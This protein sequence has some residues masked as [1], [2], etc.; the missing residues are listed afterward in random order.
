MKII[1]NFGKHRYL[2]Y[3]WYIYIY[4]DSPSITSRFHHQGGSQPTGAECD[5]GR[6]SG[7]AFFILCLSSPSLIFWYF[8]ENIFWQV[9]NSEKKWWKARNSEAEVCSFLSP[10]GDLR[11]GLVWDNHTTP[12]H[13]TGPDRSFLVRLLKSSSN[14]TKSSMM[15]PQLFSGWYQM[16]FRLGSD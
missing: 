7:G 16:I 13:P 6:L 9:L 11:I 1:D 4:F 2:I 14:W 8:L 3:W 10:S 5:E 15:G 12:P